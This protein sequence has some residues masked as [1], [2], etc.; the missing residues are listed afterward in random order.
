[1]DML[2]TDQLQIIVDHINKHIRIEGDHWLWNKRNYTN[3]TSDPRIFINGRNKH[4]ERAIDFMWQYHN[5]ITIAPRI[6]HLCKYNRRCLN[7][8]HK[9][10]EIPKPRYTPVAERKSR[11]GQRRWTTND[12]TWLQTNTHLTVDEQATYLKRSTRS[13]ETKL[14]Q[15]GAL[16]QRTKYLYQ[17]HTD[18]CQGIDPIVI[19]RIVSAGTIE[20][21]AQQHPVCDCERAYIL[22]YIPNAYQILLAPRTAL[23][24]RLNA[25][26]V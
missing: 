9:Q 7:P 4:G 13:I 11:A 2:K 26:P 20:H 18:E 8:A 19:D 23:Q 15:L 5:K 12:I 1:M 25:I 6:K 3:Q 17:R 21:F 22:K 10:Q 16:R 14:R 24:Q